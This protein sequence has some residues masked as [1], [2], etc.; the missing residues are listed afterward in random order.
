ME[1]RTERGSALLAALLMLLVC[2]AALLW[3]ARS[4]HLPAGAQAGAGRRDLTASLEQSFHNA[5]SQALDGL[6]YIRRIYTLPEDALAGPAPN[7]A[8]FGHTDDPAV[9]QALIDGAEELLEGQDTVWK[10]DIVPA[11]DSDFVYYY[12]ETILAIGWKEIIN[13]KCCCFMEVKVADGSQF[14]RKLAGDSYDSGVREYGSKLASEANAVVAA[15]GDFYVH[16]QLGATVY[17]R[18]L[19]RCELEVLD[20]CFINAA[21]ELLPVPAGQLKTREEA[22]AFVRDKDVVFSLAFG[23]ILVMDGQL[24]DIDGYPIGEARLTYSRSAIGTTDR[25]HYLLMTV[26][27]SFQAHVAAT[28]REEAQ[29]MYDKGCVQAYAMDGGQ[30]AEI[31]LNGEVFNYV[32]WDSERQVSDIIYFATALPEGSEG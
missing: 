2:A 26:N 9:I 21:G 11:R 8:A 31:C 4:V 29:L 3:I 24:Q 32:D 13:G 5:K 20:L 22:E 7:Q 23:P 27:Y 14:R 25:L 30:T 17:Q 1:K 16:R 18:Q 12:D 28:A 10:P 19:Y 6:T 15:N